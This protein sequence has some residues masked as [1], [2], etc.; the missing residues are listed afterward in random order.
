MGILWE[1]CRE[2]GVT[3]ERV[4]WEKYEYGKGQEIWKGKDNTQ[5]CGRHRKKEHVKVQKTVSVYFVMNINCIISFRYLSGI[6]CEVRLLRQSYHWVTGPGE[7]GSVR[8]SLLAAVM[9]HVWMK[10]VLVEYQWWISRCKTPTSKYVN[11]VVSQVVLSGIT[12]QPRID[13]LVTA[14]VTLADSNMMTHLCHHNW[15]VKKPSAVRIIMCH[16]Y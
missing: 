10:L 1:C 4:L 15:D 11:M 13:S 16:M 14:T 8:G 5:R 2:C 3:I 7:E 9:I 12:L 6:F